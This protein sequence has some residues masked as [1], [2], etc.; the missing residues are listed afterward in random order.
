MFT[1]ILVTLVVLVSMMIHAAGIYFALQ[2]VMISRTPQ[3][4]IG[5]GFALVICPYIAIPLFLIFG[6]SRFS[7]YT[8]AGQDRQEELDAG[9]R[10]AQRALTPFRTPLPSKYS[11]AE[12]LAV[13][14]RGLPPTKG[15]ACRLLIDGKETFRTIFHAIEGAKS[16][17]IV[18]FYIIHDDALGRELRERLLEAARRG[19][20]CW[21]L[22]DSVG[23]KGLTETYFGA[24]RD[25]GVSVQAFVTNRQFGRQF[26]INFRNHR[27]LVVVDG[28]IAFFGGLNAGDEYIGLGVLG[29]WRDTHLQLEGPA[30]MGLQVSFLED[31][32]YASKTVPDIP[33]EPRVAG[34]QIV[35][36]FASGPTERWNATA[37]IYAEII[38]DVR[39]RLWIASPY[40]VPDP[41]LRTA[42]G[43]AALRGVDVRVILPQKPDHL[44]PWLSSYTFYPL[45][46]EAGVKIWRYQRGFMHQKVLLADDDLA[47]VGS[48][49]LDYRSFMLNFE[50]S[51]VV[52]DAVFA[53]SVEKMFEKDFAR[54]EA[55]N[56]QKFEKGTYWFRLEMPAR[57]LDEPRAIE[58]PTF[59]WLSEFLP[60]FEL[61]L[62]TACPQFIEK[63]CEDDDSTFDH[64]LPVE[65]H[66]HQRQAVV[67]NGNDQ[68]SD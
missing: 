67:E 53:K 19:V 56:L 4:S 62:L 16:Y 63:D 32:Y 42:I 24:L 37:A 7:G 61:G 38:H 26:Q 17:V 59:A 35:L 66:V 49:N 54:S 68:S 31:W 60:G 43:H 50:L 64:Q 8:L 23:S 12:R 28:K 52:Q 45:M 47:I 11:D 20:R 15:N 41:A 44:L 57:R 13:S 65:G 58:F 2:A 33:F 25:A 6:E 40:F 34:D 55:E 3:A 27:K 18:Q 48:T 22:Y 29:S 51:A 39:E 9:L 14:L 30:I 10:Q 36:P 21:L 1:Q 46:R 5:W